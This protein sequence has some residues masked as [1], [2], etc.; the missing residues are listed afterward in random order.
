MNAMGADAGI[1]AVAAAS[2]TGWVRRRNEDAF[3]VEPALGVF[4][5]A[6]GLG[7]HAAGDVASRTARDAALN[8]L[9]AEG[10]P[11]AER[12]EAALARA[13]D[14][15][16]RAVRAAAAREPALHGMGTTLSVLW[17]DAAGAR[18]A[19]AHV[20]DSRIYRLDADG[21]RQITDDHTVAMERARAGLIDA[22]AAR[23]G[24]GWHRLTRA[25][26]LFDSLAVDAAAFD[27]AA[28]EGFLLCT[29]GLTDMLDDRAIAKALRDA[30]PDAEAA[31]RGLIDGALAAGGVDNVT[32][33]VLFA[34]RG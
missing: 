25:V 32:V 14:A 8:R 11:D 30:A 16:N 3:A 27:C 31:A 18:G 4:L 26:G 2:E 12:A 1:W 21:L 29:D 33:V 5:V 6:D 34:R 28:A 13:V 24:P 22:E 9:R 10:A 17:L 20:G 19:F 23:L 15:A 7:G